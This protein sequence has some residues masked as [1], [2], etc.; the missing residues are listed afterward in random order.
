MIPRN[1][2]IDRLHSCA[3]AGKP[4]EGCAICQRAVDLDPRNF[5]TLQQLAL[6]YAYQRRTPKKVQCCD[7]ALTIKPDDVETSSHARL[8]RT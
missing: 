2:R 6:S 5:Y 8:D 4:E 3:G 1:L 7:R